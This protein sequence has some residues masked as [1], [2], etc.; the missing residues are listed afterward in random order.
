M[1]V[2]GVLHYSYDFGQ[3]TVYAQHHE[4]LIY[5]KT[6]KWPKNDLGH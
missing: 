1:D 4:L 3:Y 2:I 6:W 5:V